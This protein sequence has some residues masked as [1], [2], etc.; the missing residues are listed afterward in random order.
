[1]FLWLLFGDLVVMATPFV[2]PWGLVLLAI[3][4]TPVLWILGTSALSASGEGRAAV[5][6]ASWPA[7]FVVGL[8]VSSPF[9][10]EAVVAIFLLGTAA[11]NVAVIYATHLV[12]GRPRLV[13]AEPS[14]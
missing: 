8:I 9:G 3:M 10:E 11:L 2:G 14:G 7:W 6:F 4:I 5:I 1:M 13:G 12:L